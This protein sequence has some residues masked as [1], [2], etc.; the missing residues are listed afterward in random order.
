M[1]DDPG[2]DEDMD[3][4][5]PGVPVSEPALEQQLLQAADPEFLKNLVMQYRPSYSMSSV[6]VVFKSIS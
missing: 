6:W 1:S 5:E 3:I 2:F 4:D